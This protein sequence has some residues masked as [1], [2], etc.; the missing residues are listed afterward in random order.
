MS[1]MVELS[2]RM[3]VMYAGRL[4]EVS[5]AT[6]MFADPLH[7]YTRALMNAFPP[8][9]GP[10]EQLTGIPDA[11]PN[12]AHPPAGCRFHPRCPVAIDACSRLEPALLQVREDHRA[13]CHLLTVPAPTLEA[14]R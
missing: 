2:H 6:D 7:P 13:A 3:A 12:M 11:P 8:L 1:L 4:V 9:S 5:T 14:V 10:R